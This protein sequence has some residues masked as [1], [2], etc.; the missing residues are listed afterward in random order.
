M[1]DVKTTKITSSTFISKKKRSIINFH[2]CRILDLTQYV[3]NKIEPVYYK[4]TTVL[5]NTFLHI[6]TINKIK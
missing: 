3:P 4:T 5:T 1:Y 6:Q 2:L